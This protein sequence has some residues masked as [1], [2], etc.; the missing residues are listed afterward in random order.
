[1]HNTPKISIKCKVK[2]KNSNIRKELWKTLFLLHLSMVMIKIEFI[3]EMIPIWTSVHGL[4][5][6]YNFISFINIFTYFYSI[7]SR[8]GDSQR[9][10]W[11]KGRQRSE[12]G[13]SKRPQ[14]R[15]PKPSRKFLV[16]R[17]RGRGA[18]SRI[19]NPESGI[20]IRQRNLRGQD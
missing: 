16:R 15:P 1:M 12:G 20:R 9:E 2:S 19:R 18:K 17:K 7:I 13:Q 4:S 14:Q 6:F 5:I 11:T 10:R 3:K 8:Y